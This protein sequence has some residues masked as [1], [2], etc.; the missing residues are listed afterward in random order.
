VNQFDVNLMLPHVKIEKIHPD[1]KLPLYASEGAVGCDLYSV[2][3]WIIDAYKT[4]A[5]KCGI[6]M[7]L[8]V[9]WEAQVRSRSGLAKSGLV[10][11]NSPGTIDWDYRGEVIVM[12]YNNTDAMQRVNVGDRIAQ[13]VFKQ[14]PRLPIV[15]GKV[16][17]DTAR[18]EAGF[19]ST[20][21]ALAISAPT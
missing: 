4:R 16:D 21:V 19:G 20:G 13:V 8:P 15:E 7:K 6:K 5:I 17:N 9:G 11:A 1:A 12:L 10:V 2:E 18:G 14:A 3:Q